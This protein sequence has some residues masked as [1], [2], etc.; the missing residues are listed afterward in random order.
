[1]DGTILNARYYE[2]RT[3][4]LIRVYNSFCDNQ[5]EIVRSRVGASCNIVAPSIDNILN[6][7]VSCA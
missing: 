3:T 1:M 5:R 6:I 7:S 4:D 2:N